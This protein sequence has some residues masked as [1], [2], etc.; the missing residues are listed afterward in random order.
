MFCRN[1]GNELMDGAIVCGRCGFAPGNGTSFCPHC[2]RP[3][4]EGQAI[5]PNC[6]FFARTTQER[7]IQ[8]RGG[9]AR[10]LPG[11]VRRTQFLSWQHEAGSHSAAA[12]DFH[13]R[14]G[15]YMGDLLRASLSSQARPAIDRQ[16]GQTAAGLTGQAQRARADF[17]QSAPSVRYEPGNSP[18][19]RATP[20]ARAAAMTASA[21]ARATPLSNAEGMMLVSDSASAGM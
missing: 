3:V 18:Y 9:T 13:L 15:G 5:C 21:T 11:R 6:G 12:D 10:T 1:C 4:M 7:Q 16:F 19:A 8:A 14:I 2:G 17:H 20:L